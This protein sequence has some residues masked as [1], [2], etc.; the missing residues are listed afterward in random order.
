[1]P[2]GSCL[3]AAALAQSTRSRFPEPRLERS[4][5]TRRRLRATARPLVGRALRC[6]APAFVAPR[7]SVL[8]GVKAHFARIASTSPAS[9]PRPSSTRP[10]L[11][12]RSD[13]ASTR[14]AAAPPAS[15]F[16]SRRAGSPSGANWQFWVVG[17][18]A[19]LDAL[20]LVPSRRRRRPVGGLLDRRPDPT[21]LSRRRQC[22]PSSG[23]RAR[24]IIRH[25]IAV[26]LKEQPG[27][28][29]SGR[30]PGGSSIV[31]WSG[32]EQSLR[33][34]YERL[35]PGVCCGALSSRA[36]C[37]SAGGASGRRCASADP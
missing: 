14:A 30:S 7:Y 3:T 8:A 29:G 5:W 18:P 15:R 27:H 21:V 33:A 32:L 12:R 28:M 37:G 16:R 17:S 11:A 22:W 36:R 20:E 24:L 25:A 31:G 13:V 4:G 1:M 10:V 2:T 23:A 26:D 34:R 6:T 9:A 35:D 19:S